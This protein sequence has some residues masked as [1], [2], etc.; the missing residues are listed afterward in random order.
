MRV[1]EAD[2]LLE[3]QFTEDGGV[4]DISSATQKEIRVLRPDASVATLT[5]SFKT[6]GTDGWLQAWTDADTFTIPGVHQ[7]AGYA[8][9]LADP[10]NHPSGWKGWTLSYK[11]SVLPAIGAE[12]DA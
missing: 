11:F 6:D 8:E 12:T 2:V 4:L 3:V 10:P 5:G 9:L 1:S 7:L